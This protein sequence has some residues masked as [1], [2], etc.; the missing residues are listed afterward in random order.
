MI[1]PVDVLGEKHDRVVYTLDRPALEEM[2]DR[3]VVIGVGNWNR[4]KRIRLNRPV[5]EMTNVRLK[6]RILPIAAD[7]R[8]THL[9]SH[10]VSHHPG[11]SGAYGS[12]QAHWVDPGC[13]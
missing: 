3:K 4:I 9:V 13:V 6:L 7:N 11:R 12:E 10:T 1:F 5:E 2:I 8:T